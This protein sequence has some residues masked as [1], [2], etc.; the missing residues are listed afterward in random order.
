MDNDNYDEIYNEELIH[1]L[2]DYG[3]LSK[4]TLY[5][6]N[7]NEKLSDDYNEG[8]GIK[9][10]IVHDKETNIEYK[11]LS[12]LLFISNISKEKMQSNKN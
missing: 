8:E 4:I 10:G 6:N 7:T 5:S 3:E 11:I 2:F 12:A 1:S 9:N